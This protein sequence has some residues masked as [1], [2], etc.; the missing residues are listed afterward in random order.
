MDK[1]DLGATHC[2]LWGIVNQKQCSIYLL[3]NQINI[4]A[5]HRV[6]GCLSAEV[7]KLSQ[8]RSGPQFAEWVSVDRDGVKLSRVCQT[9][10]G[11]SVS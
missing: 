2:W 11:W 5:N 6:D 3:I 8:D 1:S 9:T 10:E 4:H 7:V